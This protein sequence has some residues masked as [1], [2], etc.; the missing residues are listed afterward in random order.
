MHHYLGHF[1]LYD[2]SRGGRS[3]PL[4]S[5]FRCPCKIDEEYFDCMVEFVSQQELSP[6][7]S[8]DVRVSFL[9]IR[10]VASRLR[11]GDSYQL[12]DGARP[13]GEV[14]VTRDVWSDIETLV[15]PG[16][17]RRAVVE[18]V[19]WTRPRLSVEGGI[20]TNLSSQA[21]GL[22]QWNEIGQTLRCGDALR[23]RV[24]RID[25]DTGA[26]RFPLSRGPHDAA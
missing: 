20:I 18:S 4:G 23:V 3:S 15:S 11:V 2:T 19:G 9:S 1:T 22:R 6:G 14:R 8:A 21:M 13:V 26:L 17:V 7:A 12:C 10:D 25:R 24:E 5:G 16:E